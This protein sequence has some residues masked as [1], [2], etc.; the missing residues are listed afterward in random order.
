MNE[1]QRIPNPYR[2]RMQIWV[3]MALAPLTIAVLIFSYKYFWIEKISNGA[4]R[5]LLEIG[6]LLPLFGCHFLLSRIHKKLRILLPGVNTGDLRKE[7]EVVRNLDEDSL[8]L[9]RRDGQLQVGG[10]FFL[11]SFYAVV[12]AFLINHFNSISFF[13]LS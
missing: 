11:S 1:N 8:A 13:S 2:V 6:T 12:V 4:F 3:A 9:V 10:A 5:T 7:L